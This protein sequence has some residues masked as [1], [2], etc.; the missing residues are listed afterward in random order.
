MV[1]AVSEVCRRQALHWNSCR[2]RTSLWR[3]SPQTGHSKPSGQRQRARASRQ[4][5]SVPYCRSNSASL[6]PFWNC[7]ELRATAIPLR[8]LLC[9]WFVPPRGQLRKRRNQESH[10][11]S[12]ETGARKGG[13][14][15]NRNDWRLVREIFV[16][17]TDEE[18][19]RLSVGGMMGR[20][21]GEYFLPLLSNFGFKEYLKH[22]PDVPD[23]DV[24]VDYCAKRNWL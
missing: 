12:V 18:A 19:W 4:A 14:T 22:H 2:D 13:R 1:P 16:A 8:T 24:T 21:M 17:D 11:D 15:A 3:R 10:W 23:S 9:S 20:M 7:T 5:F 6:S